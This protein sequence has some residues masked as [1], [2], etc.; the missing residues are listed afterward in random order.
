[1]PNM[2][3]IGFVTTPKHHHLRALFLRSG[4]LGDAILL[5]VGDMYGWADRSGVRVESVAAPEFSM[6][7]PV[8]HRNE[9]EANGVPW[10]VLD[11]EGDVD[12]SS[13]ATSFT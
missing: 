4:E 6:L 7:K 8:R 9:L 10:S 5:R 3:N 1:M 13:G 12:L 2:S 11:Y